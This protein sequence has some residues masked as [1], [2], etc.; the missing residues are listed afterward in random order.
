MSLLWLSGAGEHGV[1]RETEPEME[2]FAWEPDWYPVGSCLPSADFSEA[3]MQVRPTF[4]PCRPPLS[5]PAFCHVHLEFCVTRSMEVSF[6]EYPNVKAIFHLQALGFPD[7]YS[8]PSSVPLS[9]Q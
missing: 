5:F 3:P 1:E 9:R 2:I 8:C 7:R 6:S 4:P